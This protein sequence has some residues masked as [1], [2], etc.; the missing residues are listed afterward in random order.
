MVASWLLVIPGG[1]LP[2]P[3]SIEM[4]VTIDDERKGS[5][6]SYLF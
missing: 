4:T 5:D 1:L 2:A 3:Q 6:E